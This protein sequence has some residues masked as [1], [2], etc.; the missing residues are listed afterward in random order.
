MRV[1]L[2]CNSEYVDDPATCRSCG[3]ETVSPEEARLQDEVRERLTREKL[4]AVTELEGPVDESILSRL[5]RDA[6]L[7]F[8]IHGGSSGHFPGIDHAV[9]RFG[10]LLVPEEH[11]DQAR[12]IVR[13]YRQS[14][15]VDFEDVEDAPTD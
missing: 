13:H 14:V 7:D 11:E 10:L 4:V 12:R 5:L 2:Q 3:A 9:D 8:A 6:G 1:C 15:V